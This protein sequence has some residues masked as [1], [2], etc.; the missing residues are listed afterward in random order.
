MEKIS[1]SEFF[2]TRSSSHAIYVIIIIII[3]V[4]R[5]ISKYFNEEEKQVE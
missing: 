5:G 4:H 2:K 3:F 1:A